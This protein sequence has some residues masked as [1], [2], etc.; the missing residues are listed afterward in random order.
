MVE[1]APPAAPGVV[2]RVLLGA[3]HLPHLLPALGGEG[4]VDHLEPGRQG[5][6]HHHEMPLLGGRDLEGDLVGLSGLENL[7]QC[8]ALEGGDPLGDREALVA[9]LDRGQRRV[10]HPQA[11]VQP[12]RPL[13][14]HL[15]R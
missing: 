3:A 15:H 8:V 7:D 9:L 5:I 4:R 12:A 11:V 2:A 6:V 14:G 1:P 13:F 10:G